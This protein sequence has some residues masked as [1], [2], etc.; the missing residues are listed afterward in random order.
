MSVA[1]PDRPC[2][3]QT[4]EV[5]LSVDESAHLGPPL[6][7]LENSLIDE[8]LRMHGIDPAGLSALATDKR[9][10][11]MKAASLYA[12]GKLTEV[13]ARSHY[14]DESHTTS[15]GLHKTGLD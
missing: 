13:E 3:L 5:L 8:Y 4:K 6:G 12:S 11:L 9:E 7:Q 10:A 15:P 2:R 14:F 1:Q